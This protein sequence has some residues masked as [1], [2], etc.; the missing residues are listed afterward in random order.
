MILFKPSSTSFHVRYPLSCPKFVFWAAARISIHDQFAIFFPTEE[1]FRWIKCKLPHLRFLCS[2]GAS[3]LEWQSLNTPEEGS[4]FVIL[5]TF[6]LTHFRCSC[7]ILNQLVLVP[8]CCS[9][10]HVSQKET[11]ILQT[12]A[13]TRSLNSLKKQN[14]ECVSDRIFFHFSSGIHRTKVSLRRRKHPLSLLLSFPSDWCH[15][16]D[17]CQSWRGKN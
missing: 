13:F 17:R 3:S 1:M 9:D 6:L 14:A 8:I 15:S 12:E 7:V 4:Y 11:V 16:S 2:L 10:G 5:Q